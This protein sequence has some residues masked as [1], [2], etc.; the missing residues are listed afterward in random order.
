VIARLAGTIAEKLEDG[1]IVDVNGVGYRVFLSTPSLAAVTQG[2]RAAL[3]VHTH[4]RE[5]ALTLFGFATAEEEAVF[6]ELI[7]VSQVG[8]KAALN[9]LSG[10]GARDLALAVA[11][12]DVARLT[13]IPGVGKKTAERLVVELKEKLAAVARSA[14]PR[15]AA[16]PGAL[17]QVEQALLGLGFRPPQAQAAVEALREDAAGKTVEALLKEALK[18]MR[19][20]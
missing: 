10:I 2:E 14:A 1:A 17:E 7:G 12:G 3:R 18:R 11:Q 19:A 15:R 20:G 6:H 5:D 16:L 8:P 4:V 13:K 9:I